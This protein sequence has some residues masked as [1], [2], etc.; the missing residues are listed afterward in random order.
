MKFEELS[1]DERYKIRD[2]EYLKYKDNT[3][4]E[5]FEMI[6]KKGLISPTEDIM[7]IIIKHNWKGEKND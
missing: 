5:I 2:E 3:L 6:L 1:Y 7:D 4:E